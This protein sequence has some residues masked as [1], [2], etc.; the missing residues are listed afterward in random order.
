MTENAKH[1]DYAQRAAAG[2][3]V[4]LKLLLTDVRPKL[5]EYVARKV[6]VDLRSTVGPEDI[7]QEAYV[8]VFRKIET[9]EPQGDDAFYRW[10][11]T[12]ALS[13][14]RNA[15]KKRRAIKRGGDRFA[16]SANQPGFED[17]SIALFARVAGTEKTPSRIMSRKEAARA[18]HDA[19]EDLPEQYRRAIQ[20]V[21]LEEKP[22]REAATEMDRTERAIHGLCRRGLQRLEKVLGDASMFLTKE[23]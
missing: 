16:R 11:A 19:L 1:D 13:R 12:I 17:S 5:I 14:L 2:D 4:A 15:I 6:P 7:V 3:V 10:V 21:H 8:Q 23:G 9:F 22:V 18:L 20:L